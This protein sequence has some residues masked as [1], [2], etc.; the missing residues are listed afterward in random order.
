MI[1]MG[2]L[3][4][5]KRDKKEKDCCNIEIIEIKDEQSEKESCC[6]KNTEKEDKN[7]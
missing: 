2:L 5:F 1:T 7:S 3:S 6:S 4:I